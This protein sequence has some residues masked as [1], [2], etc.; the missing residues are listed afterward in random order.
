MSSV[1][2]SIWERF[3]LGL[4]QAF[5]MILMRRPDLGRLSENVTCCMRWRTSGC[6][7]SLQI[8]CASVTHSFRPT[9]VMVYNNQGLVLQS[10]PDVHEL[11]VSLGTDEDQRE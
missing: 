10:S 5:L 4:G 3:A 11:Q 6:C 7:P 8:F 1:L 2:P 9:D